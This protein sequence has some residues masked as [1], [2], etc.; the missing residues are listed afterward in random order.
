MLTLKLSL[1]L[2]IQGKGESSLFGM[3]VCTWF[4]AFSS[5]GVLIYAFNE[6]F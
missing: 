1:P 4:I 3:L 5:A 2:R 6:F